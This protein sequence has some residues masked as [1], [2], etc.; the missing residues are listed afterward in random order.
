MGVSGHPAPV[1]AVVVRV[2]RPGPDDPN[3]ASGEGKDGSD[4]PFFTAG[5]VRRAGGCQPRCQ[6]PC[7]TPPP[8][9]GGSLPSDHVAIRWCLMGRLPRPRPRA[10]G[11]R[12]AAQRR[13]VCGGWSRPT[14]RS[15]TRERTRQA[16][17]AA[18]SDEVAAPWATVAGRS[19]FARSHAATLRERLLAERL[20]LINRQLGHARRQLDRLVHQLAEPAV[21]AALAGSV[22]R[23]RSRGRVSLLVIAALS[24]PVHQTGAAARA[25]PAPAAFASRRRARSRGIGKMK[26]D[27]LPAAPRQGR[28]RSPLPP[29]A[30]FTRR[31][32]MSRRRRSNR[33]SMSRRRRSNRRSGHRRLRP[34]SER[35]APAPPR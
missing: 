10:E 33:S 19:A 35:H 15:V 25:A 18:T 20:V 6:A 7:Q 23:R 13:T 31:G 11:R 32:G 17:L 22:P 21:R 26:S 9:S 28:R 24:H 8:P 27:H 5:A 14:R 3:R 12:R 1:S 16:L 2:F 30:S 29:L 34:C 4:P